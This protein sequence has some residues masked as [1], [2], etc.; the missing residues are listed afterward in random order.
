M[1]KVAFEEKLDPTAVFRDPQYDPG[2]VCD[3]INHFIA[4]RWSAAYAIHL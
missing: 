3:R 2:S 1:H 4:A